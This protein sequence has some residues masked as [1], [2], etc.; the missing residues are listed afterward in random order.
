MSAQPTCGGQAV[1]STR[2]GKIGIT[3]GAPMVRT[4]SIGVIFI[5]SHYDVRCQLDD[6][7][8]I[9]IAEVSA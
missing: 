8:L 5:G 4:P 7:V 2:T 3:T 1:R 6:L 9:E